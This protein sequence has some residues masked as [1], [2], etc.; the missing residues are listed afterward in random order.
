MQALA[1]ILAVVAVG[2]AP[3]KPGPPRL[4][5]SNHWTR[6][7]KWQPSDIQHR[8][9][10]LLESVPAPEVGSAVIGVQINVVITK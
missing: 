5:S 4:C 3:R 7:R 9:V 1:A 8:A 6:S 2:G 10:E